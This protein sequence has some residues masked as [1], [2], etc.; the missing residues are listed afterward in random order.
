[1]TKEKVVT[2]S[3]TLRMMTYNIRLDVASDGENAWAKRKDFL[4]SQV[5]FYAPDIMG[6]QEARPN[7]MVDLKNALKNYKTVGTGRDGIDKG[8][9]SAIKEN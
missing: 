4:S 5:Q 6:V 1:M 8:E 3:P 7:Q 2:E 9:Y